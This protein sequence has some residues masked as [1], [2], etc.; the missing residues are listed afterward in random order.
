MGNPRAPHPL[1]ETLVSSCALHFPGVLAVV[2]CSIVHP[3]MYI[4]RDGSVQGPLWPREIRDIV[5]SKFFE[6]CNLQCTI[7]YILTSL[8]IV[9]ISPTI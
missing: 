2:T 9:M 3:Q 7:D 8:D 5:A 6:V 4:R 1:Y